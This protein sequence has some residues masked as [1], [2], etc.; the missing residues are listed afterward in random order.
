LGRES[1]PT[2]F[3]QLQAGSKPAGSARK[4][5]RHRGDP[6][7]RRSSRDTSQPRTEVSGVEQALK[8]SCFGLSPKQP[9]WFL[10]IVPEL[11]ISGRQHRTLQFASWWFFDRAN[12]IPNEL[13]F[14]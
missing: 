3:F 4:N 7:G 9:C 6:D 8:A 1:K 2:Q 11:R 5:R 14:R 10:V 13:E 12:E